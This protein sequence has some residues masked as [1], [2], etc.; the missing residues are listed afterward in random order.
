MGTHCL[1][2]VTLVIFLRMLFSQWGQGPTPPHPT[3]PG[4][5][6]NWGL[7]YFRRTEGKKNWGKH[8]F[9]LFILELYFK[10]W[11]HG[12]SMCF[13]FCFSPTMRQYKREI[14]AFSIPTLGSELLIST[15]D[16]ALHYV[17]YPLFSWPLILKLT[18][19]FLALPFP[20]G[21]MLS[22]DFVATALN[23]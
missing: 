5:S 15:V 21:F 17:H 1:Y 18:F 8:L 6:I 4:S 19:S 10:S 12:L 16:I 13:L 20:W 23:L 9:G 3:K 7:T 22:A 2:P 11:W 14:L